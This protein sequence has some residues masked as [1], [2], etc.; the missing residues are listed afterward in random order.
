MSVCG[1]LSSITDQL[2]QGN[3]HLHNSLSD[4]S[5]WRTRPDV[6]WYQLASA[7]LLDLTRVVNKRV[8]DV[9]WE[10]R[11]STAEFLGQLAAVRLLLKSADP[12]SEAPLS[13]RCM[14]P[15]LREALQDPESYVRASAISALAQ[16]LAPGWQ[17]G[18]AVPQE[19]VGR[20]LSSDC[21]FPLQGQALYCND[22]IENCF[23]VCTMLSFPCCQTYR[24]SSQSNT[25]I[26]WTAAVILYCSSHSKILSSSELRNIATIVCK[27]SQVIEV[28][29][30]NLNWTIIYLFLP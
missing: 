10:V 2:R 14:A 25:I 13:D 28:I 1:D 16:T 19:Q 18:A 30:F 29:V 11:D 26:L 4:E 22:S 17:Q 5:T 23:C 24:G 7:F 15:L 3:V 8:C 27:D 20:R 9:R 6:I 12:A 21:G